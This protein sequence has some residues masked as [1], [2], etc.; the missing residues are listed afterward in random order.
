ML[1][2]SV[3]HV[4]ICEYQMF[5]VNTT[6]TSTHYDSLHHTVTVCMIYEKWMGIKFKTICPWQNQINALTVKVG[7]LP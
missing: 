1:S 7:N 2:V 3:S 5:T 4:Y 6:Q